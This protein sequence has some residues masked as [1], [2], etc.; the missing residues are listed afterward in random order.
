MK[1]RVKDRFNTLV[2]W[3][4][5]DM[6]SIYVQDPQSQDWLVVPC[7]RPDYAAGLSYNQHRV[8]RQYHRERHKT[9]DTYENLWKARMELHEM[10]LEPLARRGRG[11]NP[12][13]LPKFTGLSSQQLTS[14]L[15][16]QDAP[17]PAAKL[18]IPEDI[19]VTAREIPD[20]G[21]FSL[22]RPS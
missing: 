8:I 21:A 22:R 2:K 6:G 16:P 17:A 5:D 20:F 3:N 12:R 13:A 14:P 1:Q 10:W 9:A 18:L 19:P 11:L 7:T 15:R 4:P